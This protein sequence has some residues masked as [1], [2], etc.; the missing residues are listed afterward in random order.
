[1]AERDPEAEARARF[2]QPFYLGMM[3]LN[4]VQHGARLAPDIAA[5]GRTASA[6]DVV[7]LLRNRGWRER[8]MGAWFSLFQDEQTVIEALLEALSTSWGSLDAPPLAVAAVVLAGPGA[9]PALEAYYAADLSHG[10]GAAGLA[11]AAVDHLRRVHHVDSTV[12]VPDA[13]AAN[14]FSELV[15]VASTIRNQP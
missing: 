12:P 10:W 8:V 7:R 1:M 11:A 13:G 2:V 3:R 15:E 6:H 5:T 14:T 9:L 4:A